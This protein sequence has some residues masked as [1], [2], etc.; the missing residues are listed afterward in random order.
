MKEIVHEVGKMYDKL[1]RSPECH[2]VVVNGMF[3]WFRKGWVEIT[4]QLQ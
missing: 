4:T 1:P 3:V 2:K